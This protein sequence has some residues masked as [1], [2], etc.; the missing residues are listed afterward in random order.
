MTKGQNDKRTKSPQVK[1][2][3]SLKVW[4]CDGFTCK[5]NPD[6]SFSLHLNSLPGARFVNHPGMVRITPGSPAASS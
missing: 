1:R 5:L 6:F 3:K 4:V 2:S